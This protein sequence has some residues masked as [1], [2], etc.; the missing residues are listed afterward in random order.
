MP[1]QEFSRRLVA[2]AVRLGCSNVRIDRVHR[3][4]R[5]FGTIGAETILIIFPGSPSDT[6]R[7]WRNAI[8]ELRRAVRNIASPPASKKRTSLSLLRQRRRTKPRRKAAVAGNSPSY[9]IRDN[10]PT[11]LDRD[12]WQDL[13][14]FREDLINDLFFPNPV[15]SNT[16]G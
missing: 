14:Q 8:A 5:L 9:T 4:P 16:H 3:H 1:S 2:E 10:T 6:R 15:R 11:R 7:G 13:A 12:P